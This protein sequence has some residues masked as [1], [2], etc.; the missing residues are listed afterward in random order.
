M[1]RLAIVG[2][3]K[4]G[5]AFERAARRARLDVRAIS[6]RDVLTGAAKVRADLV[7]IT[8]RDALV[9]D[10]ARALASARRAPHAA[11]HCAGALGPD[12][13]APLAERGV[14][15]AAA[16]PLLSFSGA[17]ATTLVGGALVIEGSAEAVR[18]ACALARRLGM[19]PV[20]VSEVDRARYHAA[21]AIVANGAAALAFEGARLLASAG[22]DPSR[23]PALLGPLL[24]SVAS[25]IR[26]LGVA[27]ALSGPVR[28]GDT[29]TLERHLAALETEPASTRSLY[30]TLVQVQLEIVREL[31]E[32][33][34][35]S[36]ATFD[37]VGFDR[38]LRR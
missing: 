14:A 26:E 38:I 3:G 21:A 36:G 7:V 35:D 12:V 13:L 17:R 37:M 10:I 11:M 15:T 28:R 8:S 2:R 19:I 27:A 1:T 23:A 6:A 24:A 32:R 4:V 29:A 18:Y 16:H 34:A 30:G 31:H 9:G 5:T 20:V 25:N 22:V 33:S